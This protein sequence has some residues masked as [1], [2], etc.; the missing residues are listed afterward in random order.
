MESQGPD[1]PWRKQL[2]ELRE[3]NTFELEAMIDDSPIGKLA[4]QALQLIS[5][6]SYQARG[7][8]GCWRS[9]RQPRWLMS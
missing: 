6:A 2:I 1:G 4:G 8:L 3:Y 9:I 5:R 7:A